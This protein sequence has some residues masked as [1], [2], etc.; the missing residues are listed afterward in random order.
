MVAKVSSVD[1][2][3]RVVSEGLT[4]DFGVGRVRPNIHTGLLKGESQ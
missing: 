4:D 3:V 2:I 1:E